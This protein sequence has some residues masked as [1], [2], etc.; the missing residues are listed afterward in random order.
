MLR[1]ALHLGQGPP[2]GYTELEG[3]Q[4]AGGTREHL[5]TLGARHRPAGGAGAGGHALEGVGCTTGDRSTGEER[6]ETAGQSTLRGTSTVR[7]SLV[8]LS[9]R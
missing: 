3:G 4:P 1:L 7:V 9:E 6:E 2:L 8:R 5:E